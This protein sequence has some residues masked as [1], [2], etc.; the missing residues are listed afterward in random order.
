MLIHEQAALLAD[1]VTFLD[2]ELGASE[3]WINHHPPRIVAM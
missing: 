2:C 1:A 3:Q